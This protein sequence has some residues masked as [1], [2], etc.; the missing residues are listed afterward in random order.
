MGFP[1]D[2]DSNMSFLSMCLCFR[3][4]YICIH[5][6]N[7]ILVNVLL[8][9]VLSRLYAYIIRRPRQ[10]QGG[11]RQGIILLTLVSDYYHFASYYYYNNYNYNYNYN[12]NYYNNNNNNYYYYTT[13]TTTTTATTTTT[14]SS[15]GIAF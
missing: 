7:T 10:T 8:S 14:S 5:E 9:P 12:N 1:A 6:I 13:T 11:A 2:H 4:H 15:S 3:V